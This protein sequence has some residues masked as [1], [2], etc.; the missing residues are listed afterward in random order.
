MPRASD[1]VFNFDI[2]DNIDLGDALSVDNTIPEDFDLA[3][4][5]IGSVCHSPAASEEDFLI[6]PDTQVRHCPS[7]TLLSL[8]HASRLRMTCDKTSKET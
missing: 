3:N 1:W 5:D 7:R 4:S 8:T 6:P 2:P